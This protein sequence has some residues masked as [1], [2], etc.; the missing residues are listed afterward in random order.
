MSAD[1][2]LSD[3]R[4]ALDR[5][6]SRPRGVRGWLAEVDHKAIAT[7]YIVTA[8]IFFLLGGALALVMRLQLAQP[9][10]HVV[11]P[12]LYD[13]IF[14]T[15]GSTMMFLFAV[16]VMQGVG[17]Y[18]VPLMVGTRNVAFPRLNAFGYWS[19]LIGALF[20]WIGLATNTGP[21][22]GWFSYVPLA[23]PE[24]STGKRVDVWAQ[25]ITFTELSALA[26]AINLIATILKQRAVGMALHRMPLFVWATLITSV[27]VIFAMPSVMLSSGMLAS[28]RLIAT[29]FFNAAEGGDPLLW[30]HLFWYFAHPEVY[31]IFLPAVGFV[32]SI[33][34]PF[35]RSQ[36]VGYTAAVLSL[37]TTA[38]IGFGVWVHHMFA[39]GL[40]QLGESFFTAASMLIAIPTGIQMFLWV[41][42][43]WRGT[44]KLATPMLF[45]IA[46]FLTFLI[47]G[48]TGIIIAS[49]PLNLQVHDTFFI[50]AHLH[51]VLIGGAV[52]PLFGA[53]YFWFPKVTGRML[54]E[55]LGK[56]SCLLVFVGF[57][58][59]FFP[60]HQLG[61]HGMPRRVFT[62]SPDTGW[63]PLNML[64][65]IGAFTL[66]LG[67]L[68]TAYNM[69]RSRRRGAVAGDDPW[70][71]DGL[72]WRTSSPPPSFNFEYLP[73]VRDRYPAWTNAPD[74]PVVVGLGE[75][76]RMVLVTTISDARPDHRSKL[77]GTTL[78]PLFVALAV[79]VL[80]VGSIFTP[81]TVPIGAV[82]AIPPLAVWFWP[83]PKAVA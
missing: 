56:V 82:L 78:A 37:A 11:G 33:V 68:I 49:V 21:D 44:V 43:V 54:D 60:M 64:A 58:L 79:G 14:T 42:T 31:I 10:N 35:A 83:R 1:R 26:S 29:H 67:A 48:L 69:I 39:T 20:L 38:F 25:M 46:F 77:P 4:A 5:V 45:V 23:G 28:D 24:F 2:E 70:H 73:T 52:F 8:M 18:L 40:P 65:T 17:T 19:Y 12:D 53:V 27:M 13:Q 50:V 74:Q 71:A 63:G 75:D 15:H 34:V 59:T 7:R 6:W 62:Y 57:Q 66:G 16:P 41:A 32:S 3:V 36:L 51:Y 22:A 47:G 9:E 81:W 72:E 61:L 55:R 80:F 76:E 30:Q